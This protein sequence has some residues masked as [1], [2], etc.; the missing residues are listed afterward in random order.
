MLRCYEDHG[1]VRDVHRVRDGDLVRSSI[2]VVDS[3]VERASSNDAE[4]ARDAFTFCP[5]LVPVLCEV[6]LGRG[7]ARRRKRVDTEP[8]G[9][10]IEA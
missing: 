2:V 1:Q 9:V 5:A 10:G 8:K 4:A 3:E 7:H 6:R